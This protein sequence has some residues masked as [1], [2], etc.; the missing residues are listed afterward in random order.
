M[1]FNC[2]QGHWTLGERQLHKVNNACLHIFYQLGKNWNPHFYKIYHSFFSDPWRRI[3]DVPSLITMLRCQVLDEMI[4][5]WLLNVSLWTL[6]L[7]FD[8]FVVVSWW[9]SM[10]NEQ[11][12]YSDCSAYNV[13]M[14]WEIWFCSKYLKFNMKPD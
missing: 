3:F 14:V 7:I 12:W 10:R 11:E 1:T 13:S 2:T 8:I 9:W 5:K 6:I 4:L